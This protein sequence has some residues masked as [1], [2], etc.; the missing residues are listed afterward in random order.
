MI[1]IRLME[2]EDI[3]QISEIEQV[4]FSMPWSKEA[5]KQSYEQKGS[6][7]VVACDGDRI[8]G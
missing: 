1:Q 2:K 7:Y 8:V 5:L 4:T 6:I 3:E